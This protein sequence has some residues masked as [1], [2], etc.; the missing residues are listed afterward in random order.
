MI[1]RALASLV[2][3]L[4]LLLAGIYL[5]GHPSGLPG[6]LRDPLVGD[7]DTRVVNEAIDQVHDTYYRE[8][9][10]DELSNRAI[11]GIVA[12][13]NDRFSNYFSPKDYTK[14]KMQQNGEFAGIGVQVTRSGAGLKIVKVYDNSPA[15]DAKLAEGDIIVSVAGKPLAGRDQDASVALIQGPLGTTVKLTVRHGAKGAP[16]EVALTRSN[17]EVPVVASSEKTVDGRKLGVI[18]LAQFSSGAHAEVGAALRKQMKDGVKG[19]VF[20]LRNNPGGLVTEA[21][22]VA[23]EFLKDGKIVTTKGRSVPTRTL[24]ATGDA[25][26]PNL[27]MVVL[28]NRD[29]ASAAEI[30]AGALQDRKRA[31]LVGTRTFG[32]GVFQ[33]VIDLSNGGALDITAGQY[34]LP[35]GR[36]LGGKGTSTGSGLTPNV[37]AA[38]DPKTTRK[39]EGLD[40]ALDVLAARR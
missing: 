18:S 15:K 5:G 2:L 40:K 4:I 27:P 35:S 11:S 17:I 39:D 29:S 19:V 14:F 22:L 30:V 13:L 3:C 31:E 34:F 7:K 33:E 24:S 9:G 28:V 6:F 37:Q 38:D 8:Y 25:I 16:R 32:K 21:Q 1:R 36:N 10:K 23:S 20:D 26:A 12:S